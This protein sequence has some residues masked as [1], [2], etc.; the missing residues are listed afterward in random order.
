MILLHSRRG[1]IFD[2]VVLNSKFVS[3][4]RYFRESKIRLF[5]TMHLYS[6]DQLSMGQHLGNR[7]DGVAVL[8]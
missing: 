1:K 3:S 2:F 7:N 5:H 4:V 6:I 8:E